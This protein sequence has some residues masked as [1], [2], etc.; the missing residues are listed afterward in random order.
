MYYADLTI[1]RY[2]TGPFNPVDW[3]VP[4]LTVGWLEHPHEF[5]GGDVPHGFASIL[6]EMAEC[7]R[8]LY[9]HYYFRGVH[10][11]SL[12]TATG[13]VPPGPIWSQ[14][15]LFIPGRN[16]IYLSPGGIDHYV[17]AHLYSPPKNY[18][19]AVLSCP[20][21][22][23][24][25]YCDALRAANRGETIPLLTREESDRQLGLPLRPPP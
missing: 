5:T 21:Y 18:V 17:E 2:H 15:N 10:T 3:R 22:G 24:R 6:R 8:S 11:C 13:A 16:V 25:A 14:E 19:D 20:P 7:A 12:C 23:S 9:R 4:L 1:N